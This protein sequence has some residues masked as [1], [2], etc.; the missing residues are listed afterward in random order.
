MVQNTE[1]RQSGSQR[2]G[3]GQPAQCFFLRYDMTKHILMMAPDSTKADDPF[4]PLFEKE[5]VRRE[6]EL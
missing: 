4:A 5:T 1:P 3:Q 2:S 6:P